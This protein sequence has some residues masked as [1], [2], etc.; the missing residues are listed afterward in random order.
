MLIAQHDMT[1]DDSTLAIL[2]KLMAT[3]SQEVPLESKC[4][5]VKYLGFW[6]DLIFVYPKIG[7]KINHS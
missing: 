1:T 4:E 3:A 6:A 7:E 5:C 2:E